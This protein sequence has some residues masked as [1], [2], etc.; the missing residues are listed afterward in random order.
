MLCNAEA[1]NYTK[2]LMA[3][4][5]KSG[6]VNL[7]YHHNFSNE[8]AI[9]IVWRAMRDYDDPQR[10]VAPAPGEL[11]RVLTTDQLG[12]LF[13]HYL[14][15]QMELGPIRTF[16]TDAEQEAM[17]LRIVQSASADPFDSLSWE[18]QRTLVLGLASR[19]VSSW[20]A[21]R[22]AG[23]P[24]DVSALA[25]SEVDS[26]VAKREASQESADTD[27]PLTSPA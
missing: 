23:L 25:L 1:D 24:L 6:D 17:I 14:S 21:I 16:M 13:N 27:E 5:Q 12:V 2:K 4:P 10:P 18:Q 8:S 9:R 15:T 3:D 20:T 26:L 19:L 22:S 11:R 7:G